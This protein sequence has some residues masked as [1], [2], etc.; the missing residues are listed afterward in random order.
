[1]LKFIKYGHEW[2]GFKNTFYAFRVGEVK[3]QQKL[4]YHL[5]IVNSL[6]L[7]KQNDL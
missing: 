1:M 3:R 2:T 5:T 7:T 4:S 6:I